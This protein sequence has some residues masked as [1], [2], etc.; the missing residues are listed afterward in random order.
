[1]VTRLGQELESLRL[2]SRIAVLTNGVV[3]PLYGDLVKTALEKS[4]FRIK[5][6]E[7]PDGEVY[8][9]LTTVERLYDELVDFCMD[10]TSTI[11]AL[12][13]GVI[14]D[15]AGFVAATYMRG[16]HFVNLPTTL[17]AQVD[18]AVGGKTGVDHPKGKNLIGAF[19]Q[20]RLVICDLD[21]LRT[22][23]GKELVA[24]MAEVVKYGVIA[25]AG[26]FSFV[27]SHT[28]EILGLES[29]AMAEV[30]R[31]SCTA[32]AAVVEQ[33]EL[34]S[35][36]RAT[37]N[38]GHTLGHAFESLTGYSRYI[39]GEAVAMGMVA[40]ARI[41]LELRICEAEVVHRLVQLLSRIG[42]PT[43]MP[44][45]DPDDV[46]TILSHDKKVKDGRVRFVLPERIGKVV[47]HEDV[48]P[49]VI[50]RVLQTP[51]V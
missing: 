23:P 51:P 19:H 12:G 8:K 50:R 21:F 6:V 20:P 43:Q 7:I 10:R 42:L 39:H 1:M 49:D 36:L 25:D 38:Y 34:E 16:I 40:A 26:F 24:G 44:E 9:S 15:L 35:G 32:K 45:L 30:V 31:S 29:D 14:G 46:L 33:D 18:S 11:L 41:A 17:L 13:G 47:I 2:G 27:E 48:D 3:Q 28:D 5:T 22:L 37:L 4:G